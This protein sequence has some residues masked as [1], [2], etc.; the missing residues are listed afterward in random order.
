MESECYKYI[1]V[2]YS[3]IKPISKNIHHIQLQGCGGRNENYIDL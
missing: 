2:L 3:T 1:L